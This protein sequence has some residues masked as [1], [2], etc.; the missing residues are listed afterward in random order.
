MNNL[1]TDHTASNLMS[2]TRPQNH[3]TLKPQSVGSCLAVAPLQISL[4]T[5]HGYWM[6]MRRSPPCTSIPPGASQLIV[7]W[8]TWGT[9]QLQCG[10][11]QAATRISC[12][13]G[14]SPG[15]IG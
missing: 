9:T 8:G 13:C 10:T 7:K 2:T 11:L 3:S 4:A 1:S 12:H 5:S 6:S 15:T 14:M